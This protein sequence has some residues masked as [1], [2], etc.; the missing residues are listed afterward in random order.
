MTVL[1]VGIILIAALLAFTLLQWAL[2]RRQVAKERARPYVAELAPLALREAEFPPG[3]HVHYRGPLTNERLAYLSPDE[4]ATLDQL[5]EQGREIGYRQAFRDPRSYGELTDVIL[6]NTLRSKTRHRMISVDISLFE[7]ATG[8]DEAIDEALPTPDDADSPLTTVQVSDLG[9]RNLDFAHSARRWSRREG[10]TELQRK[11]EV[12]WRAGRL[13]CV[14]TGD[15][16]PPGGVSEDEVRDLA[17]RIH[18]RVLTS[19]LATDAAPSP[20]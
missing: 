16:E 5:D 7:D 2:R 15:S 3:Y 17:R 4:H 9:P 18:E 20:S 12:R 14:V 8:A 13:G 19:P 10:E 6:N 1:I 11:V